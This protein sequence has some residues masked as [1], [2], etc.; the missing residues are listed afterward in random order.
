VWACRWEG[1]KVGGVWACGWEGGRWACGWA[2]GW[3][4]LRV[5]GESGVPYHL[6]NLVQFIAALANL[7][8]ADSRTRARRG[9]GYQLRAVI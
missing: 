5:G 6:I 8:A 1:G 7:C 4:G 2:C 9:H 3:V